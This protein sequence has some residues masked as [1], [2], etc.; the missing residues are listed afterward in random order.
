MTWKPHPPYTASYHYFIWRQGKV[1]L[2]ILSISLSQTLF[3]YSLI[4]LCHNRLDRLVLLLDTG[5]T[6]SVRRTA[7]QQLGEIQK[8]HPGE[9]YNLLSRVRLK[10]ILKLYNTRNSFVVLGGY[11]FTQQSL[12]HALGSWTCTGIYCISCTTLAT[13]RRSTEHHHS[14]WPRWCSTQACFRP[15]RSGICIGSRQALAW[16]S[17]QRIW[18]RL[19]WYDTTRT[20]WTTKTQPERTIRLN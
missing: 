20:T 18:Y 6:S 10:A 1:L 11:S 3:Y 5:S 14:T 9:L 4:H 8:Q 19:F 13:W 7:A 2:F 17:W 16:V 15:I 12:G